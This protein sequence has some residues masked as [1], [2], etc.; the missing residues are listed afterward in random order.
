MKKAAELRQE[1]KKK[2]K[3]KLFDIFRLRKTQ[4]ML[5]TIIDG[6][7]VIPTRGW[8]QDFFFHLRD[9]VGSGW[10]GSDGGVSK[11]LADLV[12]KS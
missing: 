2:K 4:K 12:G 1:K 6:S 5:T 3:R 11:T 8:G 9:Q 10:A 7:C